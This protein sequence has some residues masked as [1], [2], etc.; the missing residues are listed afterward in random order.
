MADNSID[1]LPYKSS[2]NA[3]ADIIK[4]RLFEL[5]LAL[6]IMAG[7]PDIL[8]EYKA[9]LSTAKCSQTGTATEGLRHFGTGPP[10]L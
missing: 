6:Q 10:D 7:H 2:T 8:A 1:Y 5:K 4:E 9:V 3:T